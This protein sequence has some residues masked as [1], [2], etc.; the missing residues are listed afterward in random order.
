MLQSFV[1]TL[2]MMIAMFLLAA[3]ATGTETPIPAIT[4]TKA[5]VPA[6]SLTSTL[7]ATSFPSPT[8][9]LTPTPTNTSTTTATPF[10]SPTQSPTSTPT[11]TS[12]ATPTHTSTATPVPIDVLIYP[13]LAQAREKGFHLLAGHPPFSVRFSAEVKGGSGTLSPT[14]DFDG[15]GTPDSDLLYPEPFIY[16]QPGQ[17]TATLKVSDGSGQL[18]Q[19]QQRIVVIGQPDWPDWRYG[20]TAHLNK[21]A[22]VYKSGS[23]VRKAVQMISELGVDVVRLDLAWVDIQPRSQYQ[24]HWNEYDSLYNLSQQHSFDLLPIIDFSTEWAST[25]RG[26]EDWQD[27]FFAP[28]NPLDYSWF[29]YQASDRYGGIR[30][31]QIWNEPNST[32]FWRP[33]PDPAVYAELLRGAYHAIKYSDP[34][35]L[36]VLGG[37]ANVTDFQPPDWHRQDLFLQAIYDAGGGPYFD[38]VAIHPYTHPVLEGA[39]ILVSRLES[40]RSVMMT[41]GD[42]FKPIWLTEFGW[43]AVRDDIT[44]ET[45]GEWLHQSYDAIFSLDYVTAVFWYNFREKS[46]DPDSPDHNSGLIEYNWAVKPVYEAYQEYIASNP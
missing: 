33:E 2:V 6:A 16:T 36:V 45:Q 28:P 1:I 14:W 35:D 23:E 24:Y 22:G 17:Y 12:T 8:Q 29:A 3:C 7:T 4:A 25:A 19:T 11:D 10:P 31:W 20:V 18:V 39:P 46:T 32:L 15:S 26:A 42:S 43:T 38:V 5:A 21:P 44:D 37:L 34:T 13:N 30:A 9:S 41:N 27:W 40:L